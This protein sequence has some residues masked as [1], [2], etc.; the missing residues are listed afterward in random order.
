MLGQEYM[1]F[2]PGGLLDGKTSMKNTVY[3]NTEYLLILLGRSPKLI[4]MFRNISQ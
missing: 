2:P 4:K 1:H 3:L